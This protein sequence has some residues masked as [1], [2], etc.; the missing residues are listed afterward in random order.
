MNLTNLTNYE[1]LFS[2]KEVEK[3]CGTAFLENWWKP[4][5]RRADRRVFCKDAAD[6]FWAAARKIYAVWHK[7]WELKGRPYGDVVSGGDVDFGL[8]MAK[9]ADAAL[10][11]PAGR[12]V[13]YARRDGESGE[14]VFG[15]TLEPALDVFN[16]NYT[17]ETVRV[18]TDAGV[19]TWPVDRVEP[20]RVPA[21]MIAF[22]KAQ[23]L[24]E[25]KCPMLNG[26][27]Q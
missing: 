11:V 8:W 6:S 22:A 21:S 12:P 25:L 4:V 23:A 19:C 27:S 13:R 15:M 10:L 26:N 20:V 24:K 5:F 17:V 2:P 14:E 7:L 9:Y 3:E 1:L 16:G 18:E